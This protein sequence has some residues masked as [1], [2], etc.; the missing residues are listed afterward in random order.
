ALALIREVGDAYSYG[1]LSNFRS[2]VARLTG[3]LDL[4]CSGYEEVIRV[5]EQ[6]GCRR[7]QIIGN[8]NLGQVFAAQGNWAAAL[9]QL[10]VSLQGNLALGERRNLP[11][12]LI[13]VAETLLHLGNAELGARMLGAADA[14]LAAV[15][16]HYAASDRQPHERTR[17][18]FA[19]SL[20]PSGWRRS[21]ARGRHWGRRRSF[22]GR[23]LSS[24]PRCLS[25]ARLRDRR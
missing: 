22:F 9:R 17:R 1:F 20:P 5:G 19:E 16:M 2:E 6:L 18:A 10:K 15:P 8:G 11:A 4:A 25:Q 13:N 14:L 7:F 24:P 23:W 3:D 21:S 12:A